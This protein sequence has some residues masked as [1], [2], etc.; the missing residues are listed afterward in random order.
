MNDSWICLKII[1]KYYFGTHVHSKKKKRRRK[2][3]F[4]VMS[5]T[6]QN[7]KIIINGICQLH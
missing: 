5:L 2:K 7:E 3:T 4:Y 6:Q 1:C